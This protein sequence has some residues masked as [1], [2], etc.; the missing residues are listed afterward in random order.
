MRG[1]TNPGKK[2]VGY[3]WTGTY[4]VRSEHKLGWLMPHF[5]AHNDSSSLTTDQRRV[6]GIIPNHSFARG[7]MWRVKITIEPVKDKRGRYIV[8]RYQARKKATV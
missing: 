8:K 1:L 2:V 3:G 4:R 6:L 7:D 5:V